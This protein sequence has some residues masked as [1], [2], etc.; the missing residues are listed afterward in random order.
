MRG[1]SK[2]L[3]VLHPLWEKNSGLVK[4]IIHDT[5][6]GMMAIGLFIIVSHAFNVSCPSWSELC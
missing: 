1:P 5:W 4:T 6:V 2:W 3:D